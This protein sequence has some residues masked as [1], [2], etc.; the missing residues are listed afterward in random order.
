MV[1]LFADYIKAFT[2][3]HSPADQKKLLED[4]NCLYQS[5]EKWELLFNATKCM[6]LH[7]DR[8]NPG[9]VCTMKQN[10]GTMDIST[11]E[12]EKDLAINM[13]PDLKF[14]QHIY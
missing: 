7:V 11:T 9:Y 6:V 10:D 14:S 13:D 1:Q 8:N 2:G 12:L 5:L 4:I 3:I